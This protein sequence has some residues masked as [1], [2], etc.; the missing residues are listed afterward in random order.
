MKIRYETKENWPKLAWLAEYTKGEEEVVARVGPCVETSDEWFSEAVWDGDFSSGDFDLTDIVFGSGM[1]IRDDRVTFVSSASTVDRLAF[2]ENEK[3][4]WVSNSLCCLMSYLD[5]PPL[6]AYPGYY[7]D[8]HSIRLGIRKYRKEIQTRRHPLQLL[9]F[10]NLTWNGKSLQRTEKPNGSRSF[11]DFDEYHQFLRNCMSALRENLEDSARK[12]PFRFLATMSSGYDSPTVAAL[13]REV[14]CREAITIVDSRG[15]GDDSG[16]EIARHL[17]IEVEPYARSDY[18]DHPE[19]EP[20]IYSAEG[21]GFESFMGALSGRLGG[22]VLLTG[23]HGDKVWDKDKTYLTNEVVRGD[24]SGLSLTEWRLVQGFI[25]VPVPFWSVRN[26]EHI[27]RISQS[28]EMEPWDLGND[29]NR[30][31]CRRILEEKGVPRGAFGVRKKAAARVFFDQQDSLLPENEN[32]YRDWLKRN[33]SEWLRR[34]KLPPL[35]AMDRMAY[36]FYTK[37]FQGIKYL[38]S[39]VSKVPLAWKTQK[40]LI[41]LQYR[42]AIE[43]CPP[44][45]YK[46]YIV[47]WALEKAMEQYQ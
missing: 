30:P 5:S 21:E 37:R 11:S 34:G 32:E 20:V 17:D 13:A 25:H 45:A 35:K 8:L 10:D 28:K 29:Y 44:S 14:G 16:T 24:I 42:W 23:F 46:N 36:V 15:G 31:I 12:M 7:E 6:P 47:N 19:A 22:R 40:H 4:F 2:F 3:Q 43:G 39:N 18:R 9:Y 1:R 38:A 41:G 27:A 33:R 26:V